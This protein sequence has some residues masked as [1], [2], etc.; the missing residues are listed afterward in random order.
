M[1]IELGSKDK[2]RVRKLL[3]STASLEFWDC[4]NNKVDDP[5][6]LDKKMYGDNADLSGKIFNQKFALMHDGSDSPYIG[7]VEKESEM[8]TVDSI[9]KSALAEKTFN[10]KLNSCG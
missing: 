9:L 6:G 8:Q 10:F 2:N 7:L 4:Y 1:Q 3:Q 5:S